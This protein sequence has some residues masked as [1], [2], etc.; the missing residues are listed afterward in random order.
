MNGHKMDI[1]SSFTQLGLSISS[2]LTWKPHIHSIAKH[3]SQKLG[4]LSKAH[5]YF[6]PYQLLTIYKSQI[7]HF[8][9]YYFHVWGGALKYALHLLDT[10]Q[11][12]AICLI[13]N[14]NLTIS[15]PS[16]IFVLLQIFPFST[17]IFMDT[18]LWKSRILFL[19]Q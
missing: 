11:S 15:C 5:G 6:S 18:A 4:F 16:P 1:S 14:P 12:K 8:Q 9:E 13:N 19:I 3:A 10:A 7:N 2:Y 17:T